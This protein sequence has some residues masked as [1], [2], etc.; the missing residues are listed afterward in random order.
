MVDL[1]VTEIVVATCPKNTFGILKYGGDTANAWRMDDAP[2]GIVV[3]EQSFEIGSIECAVVGGN[4]VE[5]LVVG[6]IFG[7]GI[8]AQIGN[9]LGMERIDN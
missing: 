3:V 7:G 5:V 2:V 1:E 4:D 6:L 8:V 9:A